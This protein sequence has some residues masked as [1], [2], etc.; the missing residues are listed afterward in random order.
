[1]LEAVSLKKERSRY[2]INLGMGRSGSHSFL[3]ESI[4]IDQRLG[5]ATKVGAQQWIYHDVATGEEFDFYQPFDHSLD[6]TDPT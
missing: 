6:M 2:R 3:F 5:R 4:L 1:M